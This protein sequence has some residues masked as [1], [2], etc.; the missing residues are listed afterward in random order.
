MEE[1]EE[2]GTG[3]GGQC[4]EETGENR[5]AKEKRVSEKSDR[6]NKGKNR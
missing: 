6:K 3:K 5:R 1:E 2:E 4:E